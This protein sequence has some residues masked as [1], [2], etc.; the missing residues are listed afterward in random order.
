MAITDPQAIAFVNTY[1]RP[2]A[3]Q[4]ATLLESC[5]NVL[6][7]WNNGISTLVPNT[8]AVV[9]DGASVNGVDATGGDG[10][11]V[12]TGADVNNLMTRATE[13][14]NYR[15]HGTIASGTT[16]VATM[17]TVLKPSVNVKPLA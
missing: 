12:L 9:Q 17:N 15:D 5:Q 8:T 11:Q 2:L 1:V 10:R 7:R 6:T 3:D 13:L 16:A 14:N 4:M